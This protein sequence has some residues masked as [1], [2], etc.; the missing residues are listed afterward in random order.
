MS[1]WEQVPSATHFFFTRTRSVLK[2]SVATFRAPWTTAQGS[3]TGSFESSLNTP[4][5][6][7][8]GVPRWT[9]HLRFHEFRTC[10]SETSLQSD[11][12]LSRGLKLTSG[13][14]TPAGSYERSRADVKKKTFTSRKKKKIEIPGNSTFNRIS[15]STQRSGTACVSGGWLLPAV[16]GGDLSAH[17]CARRS[18]EDRHL[19][20]LAIRH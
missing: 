9:S 18:V 3:F 1:T 11:F 7:C 20:R 17:V 14:Q 10:C 19:A 8:A 15:T 4:W 13:L 12:N 6:T 16:G 2:R 5:F